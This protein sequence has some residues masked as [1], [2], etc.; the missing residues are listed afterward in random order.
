MQQRP[1]RRLLGFVAILSFVALA[2][3]DAFAQRSVGADIAG[4]VKDETGAVLPGVSVTV[5]SNSTGATRSL[6]TDEKGSFLA[7]N[8][9]P[10]SFTVK[11][12]LAGFAPVT[13]TKVTTT[14]GERATLSVQ[15]KVGTLSESITVTGESAT[16]VETTKTNM[17]TLVGEK[18][19]TDLPI[20]VR[21]PLTFILTAP[22]T[23][24]Q[25]TTTGSGYSF[26]GTRAR[27]NLSIVDGVDNNDD[28]TRS[29]M[30]Q[31]NLDA[32]KEFQVLASNYSAEFGRASGGVVNTILKSGTNTFEGSVSFYFRDQS[33]MAIPYFTKLAGG[34][35]PPYRQL[36][37]GATL[38][39]PIVKSKLFFFGS[40]ELYQT[41]AFNTVTI[42][43]KN[44]DIMNAVLSGKFDQLPALGVA[45]GTNYPR[46]ITYG[47]TSVG[48]PGTFPTSTKR[49]GVVGK[50]D[51]QASQN[52]SF[53]VRYIYSRSRTTGSGSGL[54]DLTRSG[55]AGMNDSHAAVASYSHIFSST[56]LNETR[57]QYSTY[58]SGGK[59]G[60]SIGP[61]I[62]ISGVGNFGRNL[63]QPQGR[64]QKR[65]QLIDTFSRMSG[66][67]EFKAGF[68]FNRVNLASSLPGTNAGP[69]GGLGGVF[70][71]SNMTAFLDG[72]S[73][74]FLQGFGSSGTDQT[75]TTYGFFVQDNLKPISNATVSLGVRYDL[76]INPKVANILDPNP[77]RIHTDTNNIA[78]R[79]GISYN[80]DGAGRT[81]IRAGYGLYYDMLLTNM[82]SNAGQFNGLTVKTITLTGAAAA[83]RFRGQ[84][85]GFPP[86]ALPN[87]PPPDGYGNIIWT[88]P[89]PI[90][91]SVFPLQ[92][93][94]TM[95]PNLPVPYTHQAHLTVEH[96]VTKDLAVSVGYM[97]N[98]AK[99]LPA[100]VNLNLPTPIPDA[101]GRNIY[102]LSQR[103]AELPDPRILINNQFQAIAYS[104]YDA[105]IIS[106]KQRLSRGL[107]FSA[108]YTLSK[109]KD[110]VPDP[111][112]D[113]PSTADQKNPRADW[114]SS[115]QDERHRFV[116]NGVFVTPSWR[117]VLGAIL[118]DVAI[119]PIVTIGSPFFGNIVVGGDTNGDGVQ[120]DRPIGV[121]RDTYA[122]DSNSQVDLRISKS[123]KL[124][125]RSEIQV[126]VDAFNIFNT[127]NLSSY[128]MTWGSGAYPSTPVSTFGQPTGAGAMR[129]VQLGARFRF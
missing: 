81:V 117:G 111:I 128:N 63:N 70:S 88:S 103:T 80:P 108:H 14:L 100:L 102:N 38:G 32:V 123:V 89:S 57:V 7:I 41:D 8:L 58:T 116:F 125:G 44:T 77:V 92:S 62:N 91:D 54:N 87:V 33:L 64:T 86:G 71:F 35:T 56:M 5:T 83:A 9:Q 119:S 11:A 94:T 96:A 60:D 101:S 126:M 110:L 30:A 52:D 37:P 114:G 48:G 39:G 120:N 22:A 20:N 74:N 107:Q 68:D 24:P 23:T 104:S 27:S 84:N 36:Q 106:V 50:F 13:L 115:M 78:P 3:A 15:M 97:M 49:H 4:V 121:G 65:Y 40:Y 46:D 61:G 93:I 12:E 90:P 69:L 105:L 112:F 85:L 47:Y 109:A 66:I 29:F 10:G 6:V 79:L 95:D 51:W 2:A 76:S 127:V 118:G 122:L 73:N 72:N 17:S 129:I 99:A 19:L 82:A 59:L 25:R 43:Q 26:G 75:Y 45:L 55:T 16:V 67:H 42:S 34:K 28:A 124:H 1:S 98:R 18:Q 31:P 53:Y 113:N 21:N